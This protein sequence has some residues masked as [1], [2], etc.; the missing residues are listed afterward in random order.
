MSLIEQLHPGLKGTQH[1]LKSENSDCDCCGRAAIQA[2]GQP[3]SV[4]DCIPGRVALDLLLLLS[5]PRIGLSSFHA[6]SHMFNRK[7][8]SLEAK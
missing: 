4:E 7:E 2:D 5:Q 3:L 1:P 8:A 6:A